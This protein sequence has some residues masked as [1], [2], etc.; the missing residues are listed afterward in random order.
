MRW[1]LG[2][3]FA[4]VEVIL[5]LCRFGF[6]VEHDFGFENAL[7][8]INLSQRGAGFGGVVDALGHDIPRPC[9]R[10]CG[11][12]HFFFSGNKRRGFRL[13]VGFSALLPEQIGK[14]LETAFLGDGGA[15]AFLRT[16]GQVEI[17]EGG[18]IR[19]GVDFDFQLFGEELAL[20]EG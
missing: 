20:F 4:P 16:E 5:E 15:S 7:V 6:F 1:A 10:S 19:C 13:G 12:G 8:E 17:L 2:D 11:I 3:G 18:E 9:E 14:R